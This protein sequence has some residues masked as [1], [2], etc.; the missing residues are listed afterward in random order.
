LDAICVEVTFQEIQKIRKHRLLKVSRD[1]IRQN[2]RQSMRNRC[3]VIFQP[4]IYIENNEKHEKTPDLQPQRQ[5][6]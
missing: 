6:C 1:R 3:P 5:L 4:S 2:S